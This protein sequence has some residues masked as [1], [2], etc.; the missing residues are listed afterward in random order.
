MNSLATRIREQA[1]ALG[2]SQVGFAPAA[3]PP[4]ASAYQDW[5]ARGFAGEM[6]YLERD[7]DRRMDPRAYWPDA[8]TLV[9]VTASYASDTPDPPAGPLEGR[10]A[11]YARADDYHDVLKAK[12]H[13]LGAFIVQE[14]P[15]TRY[16][17]VVDTAAVLERAH[18]VQAG[19]G[20]IGKNSMLLSRDAGSY[21]LLGVVLLDREMTFDAPVTDHCGS[22]RRCI[23]ACPTGAIVTPRVVDSR[24]CLSYLT[25]ELRGAIPLEHRSQ[26][27]GWAFGCDICQEVCPWVRHAGAPE[28]PG[29]L[30][31]RPGRAAIDLATLALEDQAAFSIRWRKSAVKRTKRAGLAR[32]AVVLLGNSTDQTRAVELLEQAIKDP[33]ANV[34]RH[35]GWGLGQQGGGAARKALEAARVREIDPEVQVEIDAALE[36]SG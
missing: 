5:L 27:S 34:R 21:T 19:L 30:E 6:H 8:R 10:I 18:A 15:G 17:A 9:V 16:L 36:R 2:F 22:C 3:P 1:R 12:L 31:P 13:A 4:H 23:D 35:A 33:E 11:R 26:L 14:A 7:P 20:W 24:R 32:N 25:I 29:L 28:G